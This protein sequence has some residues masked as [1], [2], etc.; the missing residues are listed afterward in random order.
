MGNKPSR[1]NSKLEENKMFWKK[2]VENPHPH[3]KYTKF[4]EPYLDVEEFYN[5]G[6][7]K[8]LEKRSREIDTILTNESIRREKK[9]M[10]KSS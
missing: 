5:R 8:K 6:L 7:D 1:K 3:V 2:K 4:G 10:K 9:L